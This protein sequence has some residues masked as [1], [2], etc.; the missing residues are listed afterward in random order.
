MAG[1]FARLTGR[2]PPKPGAVSAPSPAVL[3][4]AAIAVAAGPTASL[5]SPQTPAPTFG[6]RRPLVGTKGNVAGFELLLPPALE[7]RL[8]QRADAAAGMARAANQALL[9]AAATPLCQTGKRVL[10]TMGASALA[11]PGVAQQATAGALICVPDLAL[12]PPQVAA[13]LRAR[14][15]RLGVSDGPPALAPA[16]DFVLLQALAG[17]LDTL[18]LAAQGWRTQR[19]PLP[20]L[21]NGLQHLDD[22]ERVLRAG[23]TL[24]GGVLGRGQ[25]QPAPRPLSAAAERICELI[26]HLG[27]DHDTH[28][29]S[30]AVRGDVALSYRLLRYANSSAV[31]LRQTVDSVDTAVMLLGRQELHRWL[32]VLLLS[33]ADS[34]QASRALQE[35][36]LARGRLLEGLATLRGYPTPQTLFT[37]GLL[38]LL[39][40]LLQVPLAAALAP[41]RLPE[42]VLLALLKREGP[43]AAYLALAEALDA[44][45]SASIELLADGFGGQEVVQDTADQAWLWASEVAVSSAPERDAAA[46]VR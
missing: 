30:A 46:G 20:L 39:E 36:A 2:A 24:V 41:L 28:L 32:S 3:A 15:V 21:A 29:V 10:V 4:Q 33:V 7:L 23:F 27:L 38:S 25:S 16:A 43:L 18:L 19:P 5:P 22:V 14:G 44:G 40:V 12:L 26:N 17:G 35:M 13:D 9:L 42:P 8:A 1:W 37:M 31:G 34:R 45:D 6:V 11:R